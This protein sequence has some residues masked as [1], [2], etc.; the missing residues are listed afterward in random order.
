MILTN[1]LFAS[2]GL[3]FLVFGSMGMKSDFYG[4]SLF[5][6]NTFK[7]EF[8]YIFYFILFF[9]QTKKGLRE[10]E[11]NLK[12]KIRASNSWSYCLCSIHF[13]RHWGIY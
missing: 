13:W 4:S 7:C 8:Y 10:K 2:L 9:T 12:M 11:F 6:I 1:A 5:P 3:A